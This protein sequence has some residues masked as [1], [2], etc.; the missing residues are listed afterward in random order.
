[1]ENIS[2]DKNYLIVLGNNQDG[3]LLTEDNLDVIGFLKI[4]NP[5]INSLNKNN[6][7]YFRIK[8]GTN[9]CAA[10][11]K[12]I[13]SCLFIWGKISNKINE[14]IIKFEFGDKITHKISVGDAHI[15]ILINNEVYVIGEG[16]HGELGLGEEY[17]YIHPLNPQLI[18]LKNKIKKVYAGVRTSFL[19]DGKKF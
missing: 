13:S 9:T 8:V 18:P 1:M 2:E 15:L 5:N 12:N 11:V 6:K 17:K 14:K 3:C 16:D 7:S 19:I 10:Y 4:T